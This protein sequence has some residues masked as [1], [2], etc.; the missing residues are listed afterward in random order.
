ME[1]FEPVWR[2]GLGPQNSHFWGWEKK[3]FIPKLGFLGWK[4]KSPLKLIG[5]NHHNHRSRDSFPPKGYDLTSLTCEGSNEAPPDA[6]STSSTYRSDRKKQ[7]RRHLFTTVYGYLFYCGSMFDLEKHAHKC[8][9]R[10]VEM[11]W[12]T[13]LQTGG[14]IFPFIRICI[15]KVEFRLFHWKLHFR[16]VE[17]LSMRNLHYRIQDLKRL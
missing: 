1:G 3:D 9:K 4:K 8:T 2:R 15:S 10:H 11:L 14:V 6:K 17:L 16:D 5:S 7:A 13:Y 12:L